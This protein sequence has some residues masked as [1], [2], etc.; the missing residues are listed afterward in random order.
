MEIFWRTI[1]NYNNATWIYQVILVIVGVILTIY[2]ITKPG[3]RTKLA[4]KIYLI[5]L[6]SWIAI[7]YYLI[8]C[9][10]RKYNNILA[11]FWGI[12]ACLWIWD[13]IKGL[14]TFTRSHKHDILAY[15]LMIM[16]FI[17]PVISLARGLSFPSITS[18]VMPCS[19]AVFTIGLLLMFSEN[20]NMYIVL[21]L[22]HWS[23]IAISKTYFFNIPE[24]FLLASA[25][26]PA[27]YL[28]FKE[29]FMRDLHK[30][31]KPNSKYITLLLIILCVIIGS[32]LT[33]TLFIGLIHG[34]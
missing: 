33:A 34:K 18:P 1:A 2:L 26:V 29:Y 27:L 24:D 32:L 30:N 6:N 8:Y 21:F 28:F 4:M 14:T 19:V 15:F 16:P 17:Y 22:G 3:Q 23:I 7:V 31:T 25:S 5:I 20:I 12:I 11:L 10:E 9:E 13:T